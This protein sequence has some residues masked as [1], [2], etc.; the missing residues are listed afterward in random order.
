MTAGDAPLFATLRSE[1]YRATGVDVADLLPC[2]HEAA[3]LDLEGDRWSC[4]R[5]GET[6]DPD[7]GELDGWGWLD[8]CDMPGPLHADDCPGPV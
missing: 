6:V 8:C 2:E 4:D 3:S 7:L 1:T 5:C